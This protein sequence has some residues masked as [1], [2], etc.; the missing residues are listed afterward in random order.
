MFIVDRK[1]ILEV[2]N[3]VELGGNYIFNILCWNKKFKTC[4]FLAEN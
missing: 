1:N 2:E 3:S 4:Q